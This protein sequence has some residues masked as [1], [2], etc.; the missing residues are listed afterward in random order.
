MIDEIE[1]RS[2][3]SYYQHPDPDHTALQDDNSE[4]IEVSPP[5]VL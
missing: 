3:H 2:A 5:F 4:Y 1:T